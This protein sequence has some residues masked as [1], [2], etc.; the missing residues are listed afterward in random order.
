MQVTITLNPRI[1]RDFHK[2]FSKWTGREATDVEM[3]SF[4][5]S[6]IATL[7]DDCYDDGFNDA[8]EWYF[9]REKE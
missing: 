2:H 6:N 5:Q 4:F 9:E 7:Y 8:I 1:V 3:Q